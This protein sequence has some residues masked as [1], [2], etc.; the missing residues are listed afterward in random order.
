MGSATCQPSGRLGCIHWKVGKPRHCSGNFELALKAAESQR[1][2]GTVKRAGDG[3]AR[4]PE[5][6]ARARG[7]PE[8]GARA[9]SRPEAGARARGRPEA[10]AR[11]RGRPGSHGQGARARRLA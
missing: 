4:G 11:A 5:A 10:G 8:A 9:R 6:G 3:Q 1:A 7:R 2:S